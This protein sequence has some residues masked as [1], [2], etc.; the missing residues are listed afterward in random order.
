MTYYHSGYGGAR[1]KK[2]SGFKKFL[3]VF[4]LIVILVAA[5]FGYFIYG[6]IFNPNVWTEGGKPVLLEIPTGSNYTQ[7]KEILYKNGLVV[8][9][10]NFEWVAEIKNF[11]NKIKPG[12]YKI[13]NGISNNDLINLLRSGE[14]EPVSVTFNNVNNVFQ[15]AGK[16][17]KQIETDSA[18]IVSYLFSEEFLNQ[19]SLDSSDVS[20]LFIPNTYEFYWNTS[21]KGFALRMKEEY[22]KFWN[23][24]RTNLA[25]GM[26]MTIKEVIVL[27]SIVQKETQK[28]SEKAKIA[29]VY[30][31]RLN[32]KW[33]LQADPTLLYALNDP[34]IHRVLNAHKT[35]DS[36]YNTYKYLGLPPGPICIP[37]IASI[38]AVLNYDKTDYLYF[39]A[40]EDLS[41]YHAFATTLKEHNRNAKKYQKALNKLR[42]YR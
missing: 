8:H 36:P 22:E 13:E 17:A 19:N 11:E 37:S 41:G 10:K 25:K 1:K 2:K 34:S 21:A 31:N 20:L 12:R 28:N 40:R 29:G 35:I 18:S 15:L 3:L 30:I 33:L 9:R 5:G 32:R 14:Q 27:A 39:C 23:G 26:G 7:L 24:R 16:V 38:D 4:F 6:V 42:I